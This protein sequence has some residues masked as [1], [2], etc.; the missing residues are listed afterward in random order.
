MLQKIDTYEEKRKSKYNEASQSK[1]KSNELVELVN[2]SIKKQDAY[3]RKLKIDDKE[4]MAC[5]EKMSELKTKIEIERKNIKKLMLDDQIMKFETNMETIVEEF[6][7][8]LIDTTSDLA[9]IISIN[10]L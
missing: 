1:D 8:K 5:N 2:D 9:V 4:T 3:L 10:D 6:L 7:G